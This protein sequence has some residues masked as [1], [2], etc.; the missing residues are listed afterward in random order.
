MF[1]VLYICLNEP[2][3]IPCVVHGLLVKSDQQLDY[4]PDTLVPQKL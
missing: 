2:F 1:S 3:V 4:L